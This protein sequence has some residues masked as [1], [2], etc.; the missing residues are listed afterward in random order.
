MHAM[1]AAVLKGNRPVAQN[2][3]PLHGTKLRKTYDRLKGK[4]GLL[5]KA[6][7]TGQLFQLRDT[8]GLDI[9]AFKTSRAKGRGWKSRWCLAGE[10]VAGGRYIDY[11]AERWKDKECP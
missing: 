7:R 5:V 3:A 6:G 4:P 9:R 1:S 2:D 10:Y 8:Y 11:V